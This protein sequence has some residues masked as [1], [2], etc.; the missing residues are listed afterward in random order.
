[1]SVEVLDSALFFLDSVT[2]LDDV[3]G[4]QDLSHYVLNH[5]AG[6]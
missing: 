5:Q 6:L 1:M 3:A 4:W 2:D